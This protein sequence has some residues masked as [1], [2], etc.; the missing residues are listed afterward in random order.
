[1][2]NFCRKIAN[3]FTADRSVHF[4]LQ[5]HIEPENV[6]TKGYYG[7]IYQQLENIHVWVLVVQILYTE[8]L[9][10]NN[11][12]QQ[13]HSHH[14]L[15]GVLLIELLLF[16]LSNIFSSLFTNSFLPFICRVWQQSLSKIV[17]LRRLLL[18][19]IQ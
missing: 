12:V 16:F 11:K 5:L 4:V 8:A 6:E 19:H 13:H 2:S 10:R 14:T 7:A 17:L 3:Q 9:K 1:M 18:F 15:H